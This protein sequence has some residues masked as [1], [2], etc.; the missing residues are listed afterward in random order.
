[1]R[2][3]RDY[4]KKNSPPWSVSPTGHFQIF[5][6]SGRDKVRRNAPVHSH[7]SC[8]Q[9]CFVA[10]PDICTDGHAIKAAG[11]MLFSRESHWTQQ[12]GVHAS[13]SRAYA[14]S[15]QERT[16]VIYPI[17]PHS[18]LRRATPCCAF[19]A[20]AAAVAHGERGLSLSMPTRP[21]KVPVLTC[22]PSACRAQS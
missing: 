9:R 19:C 22:H 14:D 18:A 2:E 17:F 13:L 10:A 3:K 8:R 15:Q 11:C 1:M 20:S 5:S 12:E 4:C 21:A 6:T 7:S 16:I